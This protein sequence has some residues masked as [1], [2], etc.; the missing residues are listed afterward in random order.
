VDLA[1]MGRWQRTIWWASSFLQ[2]YQALALTNTIVSNF[3][4]S[5]GR[6][7]FFINASLSQKVYKM[8]H[9]LRGISGNVGFFVV[10]QS[11]LYLHAFNVRQVYNVQ[12]TS[13]HI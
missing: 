11:R 7:F 12:C 3:Q 13:T 6:I 10:L 9:L 1:G 8:N 5:S 4:A 2:A